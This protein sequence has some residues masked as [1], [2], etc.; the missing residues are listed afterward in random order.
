MNELIYDVKYVFQEYLK[1][2]Q[3]DFFNI[4]E[5]QRGYKWTAATVTQLLEDLKNFKKSSGDE[6]YCLQNITVTKSELNRFPCMNVIDG[7]QRLTTLFI[8]LS[9][10]QWFDDKISFMQRFDD[11]IIGDDADILRYSIRTTTDKFLREKVQTGVLWNSDIDPSLADSKDQYYI[12]EVAK[13]VKEW[14]DNNK[15]SISLS[16]F[17]HD[18]RLIVNEVDNGDEET[19]FASLNGGKVDLDGADL[20][21]A[22]LITRA[23]KQKYTDNKLRDEITHIAGESI[24]LSIKVNLSEQSK[25]NEYRVKLGIELDQMGRWWSDPDVKAYFEQ[26]LPNRITQNKDFNFRDYP[27]DLLYYAFFEANKLSLFKEQTEK[28]LSLRLF[29]NGIDI[30]HRPGDDH[31]ELYNQ[32][33]VFHLTMMD[34]YGDDEIYDLIGYLMYNY[35]SAVITFALIWNIWI[36]SKT[37]KEFKNQIKKLIRYELAINFD[38]DISYSLEEQRKVI[39]ELLSGKEN[40]DIEEKLRGLRRSILDISSTDWYGNP[41]TYKLLPLLDILPFSLKVGGRERKVIKRVKQQYLKR[42]ASEDK[43]HVRSQTREI[44]EDNMTE[45]DKEN[46]QKKYSEGLNSLGNIVLLHESVNRSYHNDRLVL[47]MARIYSEHILDDTN[48][49]IRPHTFSVFMPKMKDIDNND[50]E[51]NKISWSGGDVKRTV[52]LIVERINDYLHLPAIDNQYKDKE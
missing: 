34:W 33:R 18:L 9:F 11:K 30:N 45:A 8:I 51:E 43:E 16:T 13:A 29:E 7:Q 31:L 28:D 52:S 46:Q 47:K 42:T 50:I 10:M 39:S 35:K 32:L 4:P 44:D 40:E 38:S 41:F 27:I 24:S 5:Y 15:G 2:H 1:K 17:L 26:L 3:V 49:Y 37:K 25:I 14:F 12:M 20:M 48:A 36:E 22:I 19:V 21:R 6:F 23:A